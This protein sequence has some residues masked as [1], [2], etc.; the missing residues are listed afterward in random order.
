V[1]ER[2][3]D[4]VK[5]YVGFGEQDAR[6]LAEL[7][8]LLARR[9]H[10]VIETFYARILENPSASKAIT[11]G[12][13]QVERLK[14]T[15]RGWLV[16]L[17]D[18]EYGKDYL[19]RRAAIGRRHVRIDLPQVFMVTAMDVVRRELSAAIRE[20]YAAEPAR[21]ET[22]LEA[23]Q[24]ILDMDLA[25]MLETYQED[26]FA[27]VARAERRAAIGELAARVN[28]ELRERLGVIK[29]SA[30]LL[31]KQ[32]APAPE[33]VAKHLG[34]IQR[35]A[36]SAANIVSSLLDLAREVKPALV[37]LDLNAAVREAVSALPASP[38]V[39]VALEL[40]ANLP[41][42]PA[43]PELIESV[44]ANLV[45]N[46]IEAHGARAGRVAVSTERAP[47]AVVLRIRDEGQGLTPHVEERL[48]QP[49]FTTKD[50][51]NGLGLAISREVVI[52]HGGRIAARNRP[53][54]PGAEVTVELPLEGRA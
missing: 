16:E 50:S 23:L 44:V 43:D 28:H 25:I 3:F 52:A 21:R 35:G 39:P 7:R 48:F 10:G 38:S 54:G 31:E 19:E 36:E 47:S 37:A 41:R 30:F 42:V 4:D 29:S 13:E 32:L 53:D 18:G 17:A 15:L 46:A 9:A 49:F 26:S 40:A 34:K 45:A 20:E 1:E 27:K 22:S 11:G 6:A 14:G 33:G 51:R 8:P 12:A 24:K 2:F 5:K